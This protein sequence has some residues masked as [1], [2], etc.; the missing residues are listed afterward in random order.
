MNID[1][2]ATFGL[3]HLHPPLQKLRAR[4]LGEGG[5]AGDDKVQVGRQRAVHLMEEGLVL[6]LCWV[7]GAVVK[8]RGPHSGGTRGVAVQPAS[9]W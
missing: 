4:G 7:V 8:E 1:C 9:A 3:A 6:F 2:H 5:D